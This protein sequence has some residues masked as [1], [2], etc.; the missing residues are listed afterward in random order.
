[1]T[2]ASQKQAPVRSI[3]SI[4]FVDEKM[5]ARD[6]TVLLTT[7]CIIFRYIFY[8]YI[9][10]LMCVLRQVFTVGFEGVQRQSLPVK[11]G[12]THVGFTVRR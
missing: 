3:S 6:N 12:G 10:V 1:M 4:V 11:A 7:S 9:T 2:T 8:A 5:I